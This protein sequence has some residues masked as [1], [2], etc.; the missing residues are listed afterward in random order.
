VPRRSKDYG[1][2][3]ALR[4]NCTEQAGII[5]SDAL[6][7]FTDDNL[8]MFCFVIRQNPTKQ[9]QTIMLEASY[10]ETQLPATRGSAGNVT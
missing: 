10:N 5:Y 2:K 9:N 6:D 7:K 1:R 4:G 3:V 8:K